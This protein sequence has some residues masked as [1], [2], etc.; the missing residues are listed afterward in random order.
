MNPKRPALGKLPAAFSDGFEALC[1][2]IYGHLTAYEHMPQKGALGGKSPAMKF[3]EHVNA[4]WKA[5]VMNPVDLLTVFTKPET[6]VVRKHG[7]GL[8]GAVWTCDGLLRHFERQ[9]L[10]HVPV[11]HGF[12]EVLVTD[13]NGNEIGVAVADRAFDV[14]DARGAKESARRKSIRN[15]AL[16]ELSK[17]IP[18]VDV[19]A[20]LIAYGQKQL[21]VVPNEPDGVISV[22]R[23]ASSKRAMLPVSP[24]KK[25]R[26]KADEEQRL[27]DEARAAFAASTRRAS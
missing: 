16:T 14:L 9:V 27:I 23:T 7:I 17:P 19:G 13:I 2:T 25:N 26:Q 1:A 5:T 6:R 21:P 20:A 22:N 18:T 12:S 11:Y 3:R 10:V 8:K 4:G 24:E 15:K